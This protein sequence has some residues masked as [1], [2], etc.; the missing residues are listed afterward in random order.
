MHSV[1]QQRRL[2]RDRGRDS[3]QR[4][5][6]ARRPVHA[7]GRGQAHWELLDWVKIPA[8]VILPAQSN[9]TARPSFAIAARLAA[10]C[11]KRS[12]CRVLYVLRTAEP[13]LTPPLSDEMEQD[14]VASRGA[15]RNDALG[16]QQLGGENVEQ[17]DSAVADNHGRCSGL[18]VRR[19]DGEPAR[20]HHVGGRQ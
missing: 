15:R 16:A 13:M 19:V 7:S 18:N 9:P 20:A 14:A 11:R 17:T 6:A 1:L 5:M 3:R 12:R 10:W 4:L 2:P 8:E